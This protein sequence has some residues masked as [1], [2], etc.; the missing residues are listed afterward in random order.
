MPLLQSLNDDATLLNVFA[1]HPEFAKASLALTEV[2]MR[3]PSPFSAAEREAI[4]TYVSSINA[5]AY[6]QGVHAGAAVSLGME[7]AVVAAVCERPEM[8]DDPKLVPVL[9]YVGKLT[10]EPASVTRE[11]V[12][13]ILDAGWDETAVSFAAFVAGLFAMMNRIVEGH[14]IK[15]DAAYYR[16]GGHR[17]AE[18]GYGGLA[19][20]LENDQE[21]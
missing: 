21:T 9:A 14:G 5:C 19:A 16:N 10:Q 15:G 1:Q 4:A 20:L 17:L 12:E 2:I 8:P 13:C 11:D 18:I 6:C 7:E 3:G